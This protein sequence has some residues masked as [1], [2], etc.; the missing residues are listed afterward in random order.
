MRFCAHECLR[1]HASGD[2]DVDVELAPCVRS[3]ENSYNLLHS[4]PW[5][6]SCA[7]FHV[8]SCCFDAGD[9]LALR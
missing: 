7:S 4:L 9:V 3:S 2:V 5:G 6:D 1:N 8:R